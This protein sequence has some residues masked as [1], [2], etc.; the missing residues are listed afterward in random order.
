MS[1][2]AK[3]CIICNTRKPESQFESKGEH[4]VPRFLGN[5]KL[6][7]PHVCSTCN[8]GLGGTVD[9]ALKNVFKITL[10]CADRGVVGVQTNPLS[11]D[12]VDANGLTLFD[13]LFDPLKRERATQN[14]PYKNPDIKGAMLKIAYETAHLRLG[15]NWLHDPI[16]V[17][18]RSALYAYVRKERETARERVNSIPMY[19]IPMDIFYLAMN[20]SRSETLKKAISNKSCL[21]GLWLVPFAKPNNAGSLAVV[22]DIEGLT[23]IYVVVSDSL[24]NI[25]AP[26]LLSP[27]LN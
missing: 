3:L 22:I 19:E 8:G 23:P 26:E 15:N 12:S 1:N 18:A 24:W 6:C 20:K 7:T 14:S 16:A 13:R 17:S 25:T 2:T 11:T 9:L 10:A 21:N 27:I 5:R 4:I